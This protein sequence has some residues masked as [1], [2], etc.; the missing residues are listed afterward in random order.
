MIPNRVHYILLLI[1]LFVSLFQTDKQVTEELYAHKL[2]ILGD[3]QACGVKQYAPKGAIV[4]C[5]VGSRISQWNK[6]IQN[7]DI[8]PQDEVI[9]FLGSNDW[10]SSPNTLP[11]TQKLNS[12]KCVFVGPPMIRNKNGSADVIKSQISQDGTCKYL[13]SRELNL[14]QVDGVHTKESK[15]W[16]DVAL[17]LLVT[18]K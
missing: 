5:Q 18:I 14:I 8:G 9:I 13:D 17:S 7:I 4:I 15:R 1:A 10:Y 6:K 3:S 12:T 11:I 16:L 2:Y